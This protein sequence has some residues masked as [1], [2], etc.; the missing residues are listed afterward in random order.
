MN[1]ISPQKGGLLTGREIEW[2]HH[3][4]LS[5]WGYQKE[6]TDTFAV[7]HPAFE[8]PDVQY[9]LYVVFHSSGHDVY[10]AIACTGKKGNHD[11]YH[12]PVNMYAL[13]LDCRQHQDTDW[14]WG[15]NSARKILGK[16]RSGVEKQPVENRCIATVN[17]VL[18]HFPI[19]RNHIYAV[20]NSMGGSGALGIALCR[21]D[22][23]AAVK[24]NVPA[25]VRHAA[26]R[27]G[28]DTPLPDGF[29]LPDPP[30]L[31]DYSAQDDQWSVGHQILYKGMCEKKYAL[32]G[33]W[34]EFGHANNNELIYE[35]NDLVHAF[36]I[37][38]VRLDEAYPVFTN[39]DSDDPI[40]W[41]EDG[42]ISNSDSG[43]VNA[44]FRWGK[45]RETRN[46][47]SIP[48]R[49]LTASEWHS[50]ISFP[51]QAT[52]DVTM[53]RLTTCRFLPGAQVTWTFGDLS[54]QTTADSQGLV[55]VKA[56]PI[57]TTPKLLTLQS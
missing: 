31:V 26:D 47:L 39:A 42:S 5:E 52:A 9:P 35:V 19:D 50:R 21:G 11:I 17:W 32:M 55:T 34:G 53:R 15:G 20:G 13:Y 22:I 36:D 29:L 33:F 7:M 24:V 28:L 48:L 10:A 43:Q 4:S 18:E 16:D 41:A 56:L 49:L 1:S 14:W 27:C 44:F 12:P 37:F 3:S 23:F 30:I 54:G 2:F 46:S 25:G 8:S 45:A 40:P 57:T 51:E 6:Q 38:S